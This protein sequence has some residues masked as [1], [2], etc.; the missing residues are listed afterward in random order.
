MFF[1]FHLNSEFLKSH[2]NSRKICS[3]NLE[4][5]FSTD[6]EEVKVNKN[7]TSQPSPKKNIVNVL[8]TRTKGTVSCETNK[9]S[10]TGRHI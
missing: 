7:A 9:K 10:Q 1:S 2:E 5:R 6:Q 4:W 8:D 3:G